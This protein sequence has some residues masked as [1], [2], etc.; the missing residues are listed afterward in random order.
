MQRE[1]ALPSAG[2]RLPAVDASSV[3]RVGEAYLAA[4]RSGDVDAMM[5]QWADSPTL[6]PPNAPGVRG[7]GEVR[8]WAEAF[9]EAGPRDRR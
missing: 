2:Q 1:P 7:R 9:S 6:L 5:A 3:R 4:I 8:A